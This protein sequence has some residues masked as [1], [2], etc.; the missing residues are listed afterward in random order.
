MD[1]F[2]K[3]RTSAVSLYLLLL[4]FAAISMVYY[5]AG[6]AA[7]R[8]EFFHAARYAS[9]P[10]AFQD[11]GQTIKNPSKEAIAVGLSNGDLLLSV[12][13]VPYTGYAQIHDLFRKISPGDTVG[14]S[15]RSPSGATRQVRVRIEPR[16]S[17]DSLGGQFIANLTLILG[18][19]LLGLIVGYWVVAARP[20]DLNAWLVLV[21]LAFPATAY[22]DF[23]FWTAP[24]NL[25]LGTW[26]LVIQIFVFPALLWFG[27]L[28]PERWRLDL[29]LPWFKYAIAAAVCFIL[30]F[31]TAFLAAWFLSIHDLHPLLPLQIWIARASQWIAAI[32]IILFLVAILDKLRSASSADARRR[33]RVLA[34]GSCLSLGPLLFIFSV[35]PLFGINPRNG[36]WTFALIP[37]V[38]LFPVTLA[39]VLI[40]QRAMDVNILLRMGTKYLLARTT[41]VILRIGGILALVW[42]IAVPLLVHRHSFSTTLLW[43]TVLLAFAFLFFKKK[44][45]TDLIGQWID[46]KFFREAYDAEITLANLAKTART[47]SDPA[48]LIKTVSHQ[49]SDVLHI[50]HI[51]VLLRRNG[52]FEPAYVIG[53]P[54]FENES[55]RMLDKSNSSTP[56]FNS[57][58]DEQ[59]HDPHTA[60][61]LLPLPGRTQLLGVM[62]LGAKRSEAPYTP[63]DLRLLESVGVQTGLG[64]EL[65]ET[66][67]SL[68][69]AAIERASAAREM[70][71]AREVQE[72]LF[73]QHFPVVPGVTLA[74]TCRTVFG[75]GG[76][77]YDAFDTANG[78]I[79]LAI[80]DVSGKGISAALLM[81]SLRACLRT[82]TLNSS[83]DLTTLMRNI[84]SLI[85][86]ASAV[87]RYA[88]FFVGIYDPSTF[89]LQYV[90]AGHNPPA[91]IRPLPDG[92]CQHLPLGTGGP[93]V[94]LLPDVRYEE[95]SLLL[96]PGDL[97]LAYTDGISEAMTAA[98]EEW[99]EEAMILAAQHA[100][101]KTA[102]DIVKDIFEAADTFTGN[103]PQHDD[104]T[105]LVMKLSSLP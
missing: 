88:T 101:S 100:V 85:Y 60:E 14:F 33:L 73:P 19:P 31:E 75:V 24:W 22:L 42:F 77:Y 68:A 45:P 97:L 50:D 6:A 66:A 25:L 94:G 65:S 34:I 93:V 86:E 40:V 83:G 67:L 55:L 3:K 87:H 70:E 56:V 48:A 96:H 63:S 54:S 39:Y 15:V 51:S 29:R 59:T 32:C 13:G 20:R 27:F 26:H 47:I 16:K 46:R 4:V 49:I 61:L 53:Q 103:A 80:G 7:L 30:V 69:Q 1:S 76:D 43:S 38:A 44:S 95:D 17:P 11:D 71:I 12:N 81:S 98:D 91:L 99:G 36:K 82:L 62:A 102:E 72:R 104:M 84:N 79:G 74:G 5:I 35:G 18:V 105:L 58:K 52:I 8:Q 2:S 57:A 90:N 37:F 23:T 28:F 78:R 9:E 92:S 89:R 10:F 41:L 21:L 64:L